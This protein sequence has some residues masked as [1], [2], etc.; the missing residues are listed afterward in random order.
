MG[1]YLT[2]I[3]ALL[4]GGG[5]T[6]LVNLRTSRKTAN[7][8]YMERLK[9]FLEGENVKLMER[10]TNIEAKLAAQEESFRNQITVL[11][12]LKCERHPCARRV[13]PTEMEIKQQ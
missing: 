12:A 4:V 6:T 8:E 10:V 9:K 1:N 13:P 11:S 2:E 7:L 5:L 3:I